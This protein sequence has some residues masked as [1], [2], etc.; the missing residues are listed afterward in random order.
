MQRFDEPAD[1]D[2]QRCPAI[3][4]LYRKVRGNALSLMRRFGSDERGNIAIMAG[5]ML[6]VAIG[7]VG[8]AVAF[9]SGSSTRTNM[10]TALDA[11]V[12][13]GVTASDVASVQMETAKSVFQSNLQNFALTFAKDI[14]ASFAVNGNTLSGQATGNVTNPFG[15]L[16]GGKTFAAK[17]TA[18][19]MKATTP[20]CVLGLNGYDKGSFDVNGNP[21]FDAKCAVQANSTDFSGMSQEGKAL[22]KAKKFGVSGRNKTN[23]FSPAPQDGSTQIP[24]PF[25]SIPFPSYGVCDKNAKGLDIKDSMT[26]SPGTYCGGITVSGS[27][28]VVKLQPGIYVM[29]GGP[30][31]IKGNAMVTGTEVM[32]AFTGKGSTFYVWGDSSLNVTSPVSG[33]YANMQ[34]FADRNDP[35][36]A[37]AWIS[38]GGNDGGASGV[39]KLSYD[40]VAYFPTQNFWMFGNAIIN[41]NSPSLS[42][43]ADKIWVQG[44]ATVNI[45]ND[46]PRNLAVKKIETGFGVRLIN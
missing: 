30:L 36:T 19:A 35:D 22:V 25:A 14:S 24:D 10:Q 34:F 27:S 28:A 43:I 26:L 46:N 20:V 21:A 12:L 18:A 29:V 23:N 39:A 2:D 44:S 6:P 11:A 1:R 42:I 33:T 38:I 37:K 41:A 3:G 16:I 15:G 31:W 9:S 32:F 45:T 8:A 17:V 7:A 4:R 5:I 13:A 40:G